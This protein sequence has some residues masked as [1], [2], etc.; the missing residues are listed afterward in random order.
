M[1]LE[2][3]GIE[4][5]ARLSLT[6]REVVILDELSSYGLADVIRKHV[7]KQFTEEE[8]NVLFGSL[9]GRAGAP[10]RALQWGA[11]GLH[12]REG[13]SPLAAQGYDP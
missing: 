2:A 7:T 8:L 9:P 11:A 12:G 13:G 6:E 3:H 5:S 1:K 4:M 10:A